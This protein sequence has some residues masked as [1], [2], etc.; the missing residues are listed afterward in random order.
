[1]EYKRFRVMN[2]I[3]IPKSEYTYDNAINMIVQ[4]NAVYNPSWIY[5]DR[6]AGKQRFKYYM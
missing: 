5:V 4:L 6:G 2:R 1:M 3:E